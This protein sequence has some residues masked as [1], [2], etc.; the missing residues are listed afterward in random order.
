[1]RSDAFNADLAVFGWFFVSFLGAITAIL[2][3]GSLLSTQTILG[4]FAPDLALAYRA[5]HVAGLV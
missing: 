1:M 2:S 5:M 4:L 3:A